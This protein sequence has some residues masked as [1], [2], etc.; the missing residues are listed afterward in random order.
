MHMSYTH[1]HTT[2]ALGCMLLELL[3]QLCKWGQ[4]A[5]A[6]TAAAAAGACKERLNTYTRHMATS[7]NDA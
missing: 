6:A 7:R 5:A 4:A 3:Q 1:T 2:L